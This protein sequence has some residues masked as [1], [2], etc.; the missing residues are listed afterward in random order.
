MSRLS[1]A[2][3]YARRKRTLSPGMFKI[4]YKFITHREATEFRKL[5]NR[6]EKL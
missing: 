5:Y 4:K 3:D 1:E 2:I 6:K